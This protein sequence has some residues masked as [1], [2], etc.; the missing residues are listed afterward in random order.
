MAYTPH[1]LLSLAISATFSVCLF[2]LFYYFSPRFIPMP[3]R[4]V[5]L[6]DKKEKYEAYRRYIAIYSSTLH[7]VCCIMALGYILYKDDITFDEP[8]CTYHYIFFGFSG[9]YYIVDSI[10]GIIHN[11]GGLIMTFHHIIVLVIYSYICYKQEYAGIFSY[12][13]FLGEISNPLMHI[14]KNL[15]QF[16]NTK[17]YTDILGVVFCV[18]YIICRMVLIELIALDLALSTMSVSFKVL[19]CIIWYLS[20]VWSVSV[21]GFLFKGLAESYPH[22]MFKYLYGQVQAF[23]TDKIRCAL[24]HSIFIYISFGRLR[25][26][27]HTEW[28]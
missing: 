26:S 8:N 23:D 21:A 24:K 1:D 2:V 13:M 11:F 27:Q 3:P 6:D 12:F 5:L 9:G 17:L 19:L 18:I 10:A 20:L 14:R 25:Y 28:F 16:N 15:M 22:P 7:G 4:I